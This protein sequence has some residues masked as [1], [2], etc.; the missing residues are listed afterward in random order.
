MSQD[1]IR[2]LK[3]G[4]SSVADPAVMRRAAMVA[5]AALSRDGRPGSGPGVVVVSA[6]GGVTR[7]L[8]RVAED[9]LAGA[10]PDAHVR[11]LALRARHADVLTQLHLSPDETSALLDVLDGRFAELERLL[12]NAPSPSQP[13]E[14]AAAFEDSVLAFGELLA[15]RLFWAVLVSL[16]VRCVWMDA[17][18]FLR[19]DDH[20]R[21]AAP[22]LKR[23]QE[24]VAEIVAPILT[25]GES[26][27][28]PGFIGATDD[29][30]STTMGF[31]ASDLTA[32]VLGFALDAREVQIWTDVSGVM[33]A[34]PRVVPDARPVAHLPYE[35]ARELAFL[36]ARVLHPDTVA[37]AR[38]AGIGVRVVNCSRPGDAGTLID[39]AEP[40]AG[41]PSSGLVTARREQALLRVAVPEDFAVPV[42]AF[43][44]EMAT[45]R[46]VQGALFATRAHG[47]GRAEVLAVAQGSA[48]F[49]SLEDVAR[50]FGKPTLTSGWSAV[51]IV[52]SEQRQ[53]EW[54]EQEESLAWE[55]LPRSRGVLIP[56]AECDDKVRALHARCVAALNTA[57]QEAGS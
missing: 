52:A 9:A 18:D 12:A 48:E 34:D 27:I 55:R 28:V 20:F 19:T 2:V 45:R 5:T 31:E 53:V 30:R 41:D 47:P 46:G 43:L 50:Q 39:G 24:L 16:G 36:G 32:T 14:S 1:G 4:G 38:R 44:R 11:V 6:L 7:E 8:V 23:T 35:S 56:D 25:A 40:R 54:P 3:F 29:G 37:P 17:R 21:S 33:T 42:L 49:R 10:A 15:S 22:D 13:P 51:S 26:V 57:D